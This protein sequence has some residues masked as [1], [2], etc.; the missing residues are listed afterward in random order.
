MITSA[1]PPIFPPSPDITEFGSGL[2]QQ[3]SLQNEIRFLYGLLDQMVDTAT[4]GSGTVTAANSVASVST[5]TT[6][7][8]TA[9]VSSVR[10]CVSR[11]GQ[12]ETLRFEAVFSTPT[13][14]T[15]QIVGVGDSDNGL[16]FG[17]VG[18]DV[19][20][21]TRKDGIDTVIPSSAWVSQGEIG[22]EPLDVTQGNVYVLRYPSVG[23]R[24]IE[25]LALDPVTNRVSLL[26]RIVFSGVVVSLPWKQSTLPLFAFTANGTT[27][28][29][30]V[31]QLVS[32]S[33]FSSSLDVVPGFP[34]SAGNSKNTP[35]SEQDIFALLIEPTFNGVTN[36]GE[37]VPRY[38]S[39]RNFYDK[40]AIIR[41]YVNATFTGA[42]YTPVDPGQSFTSKDNNVSG[43]TGGRL[44]FQIFVGEEEAGMTEDVF[45][46]QRSLLPGDTIVVTGEGLEGGSSE[47]I[48]V[49]LHW[50]ERV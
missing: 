12:I 35:G 48:S 4:T 47:D 32:M 21:I 43:V 15:I 14:D 7:S 22:G 20:L 46:S 11:P 33:Y 42:S 3:V 1:Y 27:T 40:R 28:D 5:G 41:G 36:R 18:T 17:T 37:W 25:F 13:V 24:S 9:L 2:A 34:F 6:S 38:V 39:W 16:F 31:I 50:E 45:A 44:L 26:H 29:D 19:V 23:F 49:D 30:V 10:P 8:S